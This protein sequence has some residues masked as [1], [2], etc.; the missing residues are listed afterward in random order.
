ML[1]LCHSPEHQYLLEGNFYTHLIF[2]AAAEGMPLGSPGSGGQESLRSSSHRTVIIGVTQKG[3]H[4]LVWCPDFCDCFQETHLLIH[5]LALAG[6][7]A[8]TCGSHRTVSSGERVLKQPSSDTARSNRP[9]S[10]VFL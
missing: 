4:T 2:V 5:C 1:S 8:Y 6:S 9:R 7:G 10:F 3:A